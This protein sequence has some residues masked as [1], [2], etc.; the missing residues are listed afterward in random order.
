MPGRRRRRRGPGVHPWWAAVSSLSTCIR[1][2]SLRAA[3]PQPEQ[4][5]HP[6]R[7]AQALDGPDIAGLGEIAPDYVAVSFVSS[8]EDIQHAR[9]LL[10]QHDQPMDIIAKIER[11]EVVADETVLNEI[12]YE[13]QG[14]M[15]ARGDLGV[16]VGDAELIGIQKERPWLKGSNIWQDPDLQH[17]QNE[18]ASALR[19]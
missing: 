15:V 7:P 1:R 9:E 10:A 14:I 3:A 18:N 19:A 2:G 11:A 16:E 4:Q 13:A 5:H 6:D 17:K 12:L 8:L